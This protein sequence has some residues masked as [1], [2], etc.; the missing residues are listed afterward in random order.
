M[1]RLGQRSAELAWVWQGVLEASELSSVAGLLFLP[2]VV[3]G[4]EGES[5]EVGQATLG[6]KRGGRGQRSKRGVW[7]SSGCALLPGG[8]YGTGH[9]PQVSSVVV[10]RGGEASRGNGGT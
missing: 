8:A 7:Q 6:M 4:E 1:A 2:A 3:A 10:L 9:R 5:S